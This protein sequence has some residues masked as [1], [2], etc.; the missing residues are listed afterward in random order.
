MANVHKWDLLQLDVNNA[1]LH[2]DLHEVYMKLPEGLSHHGNK[3]C[4][5]K[6]SLY[7]LKQASRQGFAKLLNELQLQ[8]YHQSHSDYSL[9][10][11]KEDPSII[12]VAISVV[13]IILTGNNKQGC[14][15]IT[16]LKFHLDKIFSIK[17]LGRLSFFLGLE[18]GYVPAGITVTQHKFTKEIL[19]S[20]GITHFKK[21]VTPL[22]L[23][24]KL[25]MEDGQLLS[26]PSY[27]RSMLVGKLNFLTNTRPILLT[28]ISADT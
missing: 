20:S 21:A 12:L 1:F 8:G 4:R 19:Q 13:D 5:L 11:K 2:G 23:N 25:T 17:D 10:I 14:Q 15:G 9:F 6:K 27:F 3:V 28:Q 7:G 26:D 16:A 24:L 18:I 22:P